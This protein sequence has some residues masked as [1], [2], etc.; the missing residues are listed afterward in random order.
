LEALDD[1]DVVLFRDEHGIRPVCPFFELH[2]ADEH[3]EGPLTITRLG[4]DGLT[5]ADLTWSIDHAKIKAAALTGSSG[6]RIEASFRLRGDDHALHALIGHSPVGDDALVPPGGAGIPMG[7]FQLV[8]PNVPFPGI[9]A[10]FYAP[11][12]RVYG[13]ANAATRTA[14]AAHSF[15]AWLAERLLG[16]GAG[17]AAWR[18]ITLP[19]AGPGLSPTAAWPNHRLLTYNSIWHAVPRLI[20]GWRKLSALLV[21]EQL[22]ELLRFVI[23]PSASA[24]KLPP[25]LFAQIQADGAVLSSLGLIDDMGDG[26]ISCRIGHLHASARCGWSARFCTRSL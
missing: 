2:G 4:Q 20:S 8:R 17:N 5:L 12:G 3:G 15:T 9:R 22:S 10:R 7:A 24:G 26:Q 14:G 18:E 19:G 25:G 6:D 1:E 21:R 11:A 23:G 13:P 16:N